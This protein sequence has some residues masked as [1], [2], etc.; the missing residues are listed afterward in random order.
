MT[1]I[2][3]RVEW[4]SATAFP[5]TMVFN[6]H[7]IGWATGFFW[8]HENRTYLVSNWHVFSGR[9]P[10]TG[11]AKNRDGAVPDSLILNHYVGLTGRAIRYTV[12]LSDEAGN[13]T[14][15]QHRS[16]GQRVDLGMMEMPPALL[17][18]AGSDVIPCVNTGTIQHHPNLQ[19]SDDRDVKLALPVGLDV[20]VLGFPLG[21]QGGHL[22]PIWKR[23]SLASE[24]SL[25]YADLPCFL[26]D[27]ATREG[28]SGGPVLARSIGL[29]V[30]DDEHVI[31]GRDFTQFIGVYSGRSVRTEDEA[32]LGFVW[33][34]AA[35][36]AIM[37][38]GVPG[39]YELISC[40]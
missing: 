25:D 32:Q 6:G 4:W 26:I 24:F 36:E 18:V 9:V 3:K 38:E 16:F 37:R 5:V 8:K 31:F 30:T 11:Q 29:A 21:I 20:F 35:I 19:V 40:R 7:E 17:N 12:A 39:T 14:W 33:K 1:G 2:R 15:R 23:G 22:F 34:E 13:S 27:T 10:S 28:M